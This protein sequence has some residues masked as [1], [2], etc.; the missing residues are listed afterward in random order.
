MKMSVGRAG[1]RLHSSGEVSLLVQPI[2]CYV[3]KPVFTLVVTAC[4]KHIDTPA[5]TVGRNVRT[6]SATAGSRNVFSWRVLSSPNA[7]SCCYGAR[8]PKKKLIWSNNWNRAAASFHH[9]AV[10]R[11]TG[12]HLNR[13]IV[14]WNPIRTK[15][16]KMLCSQSLLVSWF[17]FY[18]SQVSLTNQGTG[19]VS[20]TEDG[21]AQAFVIFY[22]GVT[23]AGR[24]MYHQEGMSSCALLP[25]DAE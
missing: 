10:E 9:P 16:G 2:R 8:E 7:S 25:P 20:A 13:P 19:H 21:S 3:H 6:I 11:A 23:R 18:K 5:G 15:D 14:A 17:L 4:V 1:S 22:T 12:S 24:K